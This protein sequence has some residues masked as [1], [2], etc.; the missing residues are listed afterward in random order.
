MGRLP[1]TKFRGKE[2]FI[3]E[4]LREIRDVD[5][6]HERVSFDEWSTEKADREIALDDLV[7]DVM[8][9]KASAI[10]NDGEEAQIAFLKGEGWTDEGNREGH[11]GEGG[12]VM[13]DLRNKF[14][15]DAPEVQG[16]LP[17]SGSELHLDGWGLGS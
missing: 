3:D 2:W 8:S 5:N 9:R 6:P 1:T 16:G 11:K 17:R 12:R 10:N 7:H 14:D 15:V 4:R 13:E